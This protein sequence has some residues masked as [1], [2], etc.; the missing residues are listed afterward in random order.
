MNLNPYK[1]WLIF[2]RTHERDIEYAQRRRQHRP[3][4]T[5][6][7]EHVCTFLCSIG[8]RLVRWGRYLESHFAPLEEV[9]QQERKLKARRV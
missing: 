7:D 6:L 4:R 9:E 8:H 3:V 5:P 2:Q 1:E